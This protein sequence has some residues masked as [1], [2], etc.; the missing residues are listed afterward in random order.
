VLGWRVRRAKAM[1]SSRADHAD[2]A[3]PVQA[4][5]EGEAQSVRRYSGIEYSASD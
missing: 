3:T 4:I 2:K 1:L 5:T